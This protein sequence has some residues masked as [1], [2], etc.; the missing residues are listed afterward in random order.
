[1]HKVFIIYYKIHMYKWNK[2]QYF[3]FNIR[4]IKNI[5]EPRDFETRTKKTSKTIYDVQQSF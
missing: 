2:R 4:L 1:M 5:I 3:S